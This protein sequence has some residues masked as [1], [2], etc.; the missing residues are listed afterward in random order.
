MLSEN[1]QS[2]MKYQFLVYA[3][4]LR[5]APVQE[6]TGRIAR[7]LVDGAVDHRMEGFRSRPFSPGS[8]AVKGSVK[9]DKKGVSRGHFTIPIASIK[10]F[11]LPDEV[12][13]ELLD[14]LKSPIFSTW[15]CIRMPALLFKKCCRSKTQRPNAHHRRRFYHA[16]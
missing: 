8:F 1:N 14:H 12:K 2:I 10:N 3:A 6:T 9:A 4:L 13:P 11:D 7:I 16:G 5:P 15:R